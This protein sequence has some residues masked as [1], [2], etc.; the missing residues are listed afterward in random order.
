MS[1]KSPY[2]LV[3]IFPL[4]VSPEDSWLQ[5]IIAY[6][7]LTKGIC[8]DVDSCCVYLFLQLYFH[9]CSPLYY[10]GCKRPVTETMSGF[11]LHQHHCL[12]YVSRTAGHLLKTKNKWV[13]PE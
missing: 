4:Q 1:W 12:L 10:S 2:K 6:I 8:Q 13:A 11:L 3:Q 5:S 9:A 7:F